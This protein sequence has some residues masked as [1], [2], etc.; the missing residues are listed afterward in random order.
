MADFSRLD[1]QS[2]QRFIDGDLTTFIADTFDEIHD[3]LVTTVEKLLTPQGDNL[4]GIDGGKFSEVLSDSGFTG[5]T[6]GGDSGGSG[7]DNG[8]KGGKDK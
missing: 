4:G 3:G 6:G 8:D 5:G 7:G 1:K 2:I